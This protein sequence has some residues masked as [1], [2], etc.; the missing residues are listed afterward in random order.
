MDHVVPLSRGGS[1]NKANKVGACVPCNR[2]K[3][4]MTLEEYALWKLSQK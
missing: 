4:D 2:E 3:G 1:N